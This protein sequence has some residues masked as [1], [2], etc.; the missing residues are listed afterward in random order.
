M[1]QAFAVRCLQIDRIVEKVRAYHNASPLYYHYIILHYIV[2]KVSASDV[3]IAR[4]VVRGV[5]YISKGT[6]LYSIFYIRRS[7]SWPAVTSNSRGGGNLVRA[8]HVHLHIRL[9]YTHT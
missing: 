5:A 9:C 6:I 3:G 2:E 7:A 8:L 1:I 4:I